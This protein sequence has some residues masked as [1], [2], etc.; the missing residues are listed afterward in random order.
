MYPEVVPFGLR[1]THSER[2]RHYKSQVLLQIPFPSLPLAHVHHTGTYSP[3]TEA[4]E[5][6]DSNSKKTDDK[7]TEIFGYTLGFVEPP[8]PTSN[9]REVAERMDPGEQKVSLDH[10]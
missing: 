5:M 6:Y 8:I 3:V 10:P 9:L 4:R 1:R 2:L 7:V